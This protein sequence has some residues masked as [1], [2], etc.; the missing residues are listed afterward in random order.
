MNPRNPKYSLRK[1]VWIAVLSGLP[2]LVGTLV[3]L[4][5]GKHDKNTWISILYLIGFFWVF[6]LLVLIDSIRKP[7]QILSNILSALG[8][9]DYSMRGSHADPKDPIGLAIWETNRLADQ[10]QEERRIRLEQH[11]LF[12]KVLREI[13]IAIFCFNPENRLV[14]VNQYAAKLYGK[15]PE[16]LIGQPLT[17]LDLEFALS[18]AYATGHNHTFPHKESRWLVKHGSYRE[19]GRPH[20]M[21]LL[22]DIKDTL[23]EEEL[24]AWRKLIR[25]LGHELI[26]SMTPMK[27]MAAGM[28]RIVHQDP[29]P[30]EW[31]EDLDEGFRVIINRV[32]NLSRFVKNYSQIARQP[33]PEKRHF[34]L[35]DVVLRLRKLPEFQ[36]LQIVSS[37][38]IELVADEAQIEQVLINLFK[39][40]VEA[41]EGKS[42]AVT[43]EW[44]QTSAKMINL[45]ILDEGH[46]ILNPDNLFIPY[47]TTKTEGNGIG[48]IVSRQIIEAHG[49]SL[50]LENRINHRGCRATIALPIG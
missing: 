41:S 21:I 35:E 2:G 34:R 50:K 20:R 44:K 33:M 39:N 3:L 42:G 37:P 12:D 43:V 11:R 25:V 13:D 27:T 4:I 22:A 49:G 32:D 24:G 19:E 47:F 16:Q 36:M 17:E 14:I 6:A 31:Q 1:T 26:N 45:D 10:L 38:P 5:L 23:R 48:L 30:D 40:A 18:A 8:E 28:Q 46:G 15:K 7:W 9:N 29:L